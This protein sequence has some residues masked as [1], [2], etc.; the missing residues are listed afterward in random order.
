MAHQNQAMLVRSEQI[1]I[2]GAILI[3][4]TLLPLELSCNIHST[5]KP[6]DRGIL[7]VA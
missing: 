4:R 1:L 6:I 3:A 5:L 2:D 7:N